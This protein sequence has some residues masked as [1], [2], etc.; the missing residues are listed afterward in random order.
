M[1]KKYTAYTSKYQTIF[2][3]KQKKTFLKTYVNK[4]VQE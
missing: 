3:A 2:K 1:K 4:E